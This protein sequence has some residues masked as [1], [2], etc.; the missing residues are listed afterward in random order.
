MPI[1]SSNVRV[2]GNGGNQ[3]STS[4]GI[5]C[6]NDENGD[7]TCSVDLHDNEIYEMVDPDEEDVRMHAIAQTMSNSEE[8]KTRQKKSLLLHPCSSQ[9]RQKLSV[10]CL[11]RDSIEI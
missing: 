11:V 9:P 10:N 5:Q 4:D 2:L 6:E 3:T 1:H 8:G 7:G